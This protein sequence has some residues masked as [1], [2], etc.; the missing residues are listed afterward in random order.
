MMMIDGTECYGAD[1]LQQ[2]QS[3]GFRKR[4]IQC[5]TSL[6][7]SPRDAKRRRGA[8]TP[9]PSSSPP[10]EHGVVA[11]FLSTPIHAQ[12]STLREKSQAVGTDTT[13]RGEDDCQARGLLALEA[14]VRS[15]QRDELDRAR[16]A[17]HVEEMQLE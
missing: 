15:R 9:P 7:A 16:A 17:F 8:P 6:K 13:L 3:T 14:A 4:W 10:E 12:S 5:C 2:P 1:G 11:Y